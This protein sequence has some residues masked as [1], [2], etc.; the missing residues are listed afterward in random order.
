MNTDTR[1]FTASLSGVFGFPVTP[2]KKD[3]SLDLHAL[4]R[5][6]AAMAAH[7]FCALVA[8]G[9]TGELYRFLRTRS[10]MSLRQASKQ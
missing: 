6:V 5:N 9:G 3:L 8:A 2:F 4:R 7:P 10:K 1:K